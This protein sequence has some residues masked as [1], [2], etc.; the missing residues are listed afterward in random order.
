MTSAPPIELSII[1]PAY[2]EGHRL[3]SS[4]RSIVENIDHFLP[5]YEVIIV[6]DGSTDNTLAEA[7]RLSREDV[8]VISYDKNEGKGFAIRQGMLKARG[9]FRLFM[10][11]DL[12][13][14]LKAIR[15]FY[16]IMASQP[17]DVLIGDRKSDSS[18]QRVR[19]P[20]LRRLLGKG[21]TLLSQVL[22]VCPFKDFTCGFKMFTARSA[23]L[24][25]SRQ[26]IRR[27]SFDS[28]VLFIARKYGLA[29][30]EVPVIWRHQGQSKVRLVRDILSS[31]SGLLLIKWN[32]LKGLYDPA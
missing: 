8:L 11:V 24:I 2:N 23:Q 9:K 1:L 22:L 3:V 20:S 27:W 10:D 32:D 14:D 21:F 4:V 17:V 29:V 18:F 25:F 6:N 26:R 30:R 13:T 19:Q 15:G 28:E 7:K 12:A 5:T 16:Q 31:L